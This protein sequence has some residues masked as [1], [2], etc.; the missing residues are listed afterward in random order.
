VSTGRG[1]PRRLL[2]TTQAVFFLAIGLC[3]LIAYGPSAESSGI[4]FFGVH[5]PTVLLVAVA[6]GAGAI[7]L[8]RAATQL[9]SRGDE[10]VV[11]TM[12]VAALGLL[13]E[14][15]TPYNH[16]TFLNWAHM[17]IGVAIGVAQMGASCWVV[18]HDRRRTIV[19]ATIVQLI[20]GLM[21]AASLPNWGFSHMLE[22]EVL[23][24]LGYAGCLVAWCGRG[25]RVE[26]WERHDDVAD[27]T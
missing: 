27:A 9:S 8:W 13:L 16:G 7:G 26:N 15:A 5:A 12:R 23:F 6:Y 2:L 4:S 1:N 19:A 14:L 18:V 21:A 25:P 24:A 10:V 20:G 11:V 3:S 22:G 17:S